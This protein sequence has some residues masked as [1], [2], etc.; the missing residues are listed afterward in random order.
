MYDL[1][2]Q[3]AAFYQFMI[4]NTE[5]ELIYDN[6]TRLAANISKTTYA[7]V[8]FAMSDKIGRAHV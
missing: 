8:N 4:L 7:F 5:K 6:L 2:E 1:E 3:L